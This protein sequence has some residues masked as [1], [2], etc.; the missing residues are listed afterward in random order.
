MLRHAGGG[1]V[2]DFWEVPSISKMLKVNITSIVMY[3]PLTHSNMF[4]SI[5]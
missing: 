3:R 4:D 2:G 5:Y 1:D